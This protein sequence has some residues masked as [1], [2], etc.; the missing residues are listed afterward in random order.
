MAL[1]SHGPQQAGRPWIG[2]EHTNKVRIPLHLLR[3]CDASFE[4]PTFTG[5]QEVAVHLHGE[6]D[7]DL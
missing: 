7:Q 3:N 1:Q 5:E 6:V 4:Y 2:L